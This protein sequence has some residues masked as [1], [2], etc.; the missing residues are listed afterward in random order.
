MSFSDNFLALVCRSSRRREWL[1]GTSLRG[2]DGGLPTRR[3][4]TVS[5]RTTEDL[6]REGG[7]V[8]EKCGIGGCGC[9]GSRYCRGDHIAVRMLGPSILFTVCRRDVARRCARPEIDPGRQRQLIHLSVSTRAMSWVS[10]TKPAQM[11]HRCT[12]VVIRFARGVGRALQIDTRPSTQS[13]K[14]ARDAS[15]RTAPLA[16][17]L[18]SPALPAYIPRLTRLSVTDRSFQ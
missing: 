18:F 9:H 6:L 8:L 14:P 10:L 7:S 13:A 11:S 15:S 4:A 16:L 1:D 2:S 5:R 12:A 17:L 3:V